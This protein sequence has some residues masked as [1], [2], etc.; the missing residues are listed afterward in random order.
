MYS[1]LLLQNVDDVITGGTVILVDARA[2]L[3]N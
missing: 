3:A 1:R 2:T